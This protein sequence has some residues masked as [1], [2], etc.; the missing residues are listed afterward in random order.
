[1]PKPRPY[2]DEVQV[3][4]GVPGDVCMQ[5]CGHGLRSPSSLA[6]GRVGL[7]AAHCVLFAWANYTVVASS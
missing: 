5:T 2:A 4:Q 1:M 6:F 7:L 3:D